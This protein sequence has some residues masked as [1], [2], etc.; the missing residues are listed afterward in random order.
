MW[1]HHGEHLLL[2]Q[3]PKLQSLRAVNENDQAIQD[4]LGYALGKTE[5][6]Q[7]NIAERT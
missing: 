2:S 4:E 3:K 6:P 1:F 5:M 7:P